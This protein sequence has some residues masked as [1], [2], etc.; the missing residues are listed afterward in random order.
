[1]NL[2]DELRLAL[3]NGS[4]TLGKTTDKCSEDEFNLEK[5]LLI[6]SGIEAKEKLAKYAQKITKL[7]ED[8]HDYLAGEVEAL[9]KEG[10]GHK[11]QGLS[12]AFDERRSDLIAELLHKF[13]WKHKPLRFGGSNPLLKG[14]VDAEF[15]FWKSAVGNAFALTSLYTVLAQRN[16]GKRTNLD[17]LA[18]TPKSIFYPITRLYF[19][20]F[21]GFIDIDN[22][23][24]H[25]YNTL[26]FHQVHCE[27]DKNRDYLEFLSNALVAKGEQLQERYPEE[28]VQQFYKALDV[29]PD[30]DWA[31]TKM[32]QLWLNSGD[33]HYAKDCLKKALCLNPK[34]KEVARLLFQNISAR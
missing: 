28:A 23:S 27:K 12:P 4:L 29:N 24:A 34:N 17:V 7:N 11:S 18:V 31:Y 14:A 22:T 33:L 10:G 32:G 5:A 26:R 19:N 21:N 13:L 30:N 2:E 20:R 1:M 16:L 8:F 25:G 9:K 3:F 6:I 15:S